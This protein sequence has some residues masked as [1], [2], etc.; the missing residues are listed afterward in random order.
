MSGTLLHSR[1]DCRITST[2]NRALRSLGRTLFSVIARLAG[3]KVSDPTSG[4]QAMNR[5]VLELYAGDFF[6][7]DYPDVDVLLTAYRY[8]LRVGEESVEMSEGVRP[9][10]MHGGW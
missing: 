9:S 8:G 10:S 7:A 2:W 3:L 1:S 4:F 6:P 5:R